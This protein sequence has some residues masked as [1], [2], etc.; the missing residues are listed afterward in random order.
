ML[1]GEEALQLLGLPLRRELRQSPLGAV[2]QEAAEVGDRGPAGIFAILVSSCPCPPFPRPLPLGVRGLAHHTAVAEHAFAV[3]DR[4]KVVQERAED[5]GEERLGRGVGLR[6]PLPPGIRLVLRRA[7]RV[8]GLLLFAVNAAPQMFAESAHGV[9]EGSGIRDDGC[10]DPLIGTAGGGSSGEGGPKKI[11]QKNGGQKNE[12]KEY[13]GKEDSLTPRRKAQRTV[14]ALRLAAL[15][16]DCFCGKEN[17]G[18]EYGRDQSGT[19]IA[20]N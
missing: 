18:K 5:A 10:F 4:A 15:R 12:S 1:L 2:R 11:R 16:E 19:L 3:Q 13:A 8:A 7:G 14:S 20:T 6:Q 9:D 17:A